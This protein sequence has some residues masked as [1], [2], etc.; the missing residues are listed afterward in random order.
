MV[1]SYFAGDVSEIGETQ[2]KD[3]VWRVVIYM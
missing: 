1:R 2:M 3:G